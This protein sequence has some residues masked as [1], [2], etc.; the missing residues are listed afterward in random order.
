MNVCYA[1]YIGEAKEDPKGG[2]D[3]NGK[4]Q[5]MKK[6]KIKDLSER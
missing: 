6:A 5:L 2:S 4:N 3:T 1:L